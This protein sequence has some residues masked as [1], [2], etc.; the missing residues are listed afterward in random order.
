M[1]HLALI[2]GLKGEDQPLK[3]VHGETGKIQDLRRAS[4]EIDDPSHSHS[5]SLLS[6]EA[7]YTLN[8]DELY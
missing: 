7:Q 1:G 6:L 4:L 3:L 5:G 2:R 8:Q